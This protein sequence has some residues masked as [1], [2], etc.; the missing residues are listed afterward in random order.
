M[1][2]C[3]R[4]ARTAS[5]QAFVNCYL[6]EVD[7]GS[8][9]SA[10]EFIARTGVHLAPD[11]KSVVEVALLDQGRTIAFGVSHRSLVGRHALIE[12]HESRA[13]AGAYR[14]LD[15]VS[16]QL[17]LIEAIYR[18]APESEQRL[19]LLSRVVE[20]HQLMGKYLRRVTGDGRESI[21]GARGSFIE[22]EQTVVFGHWLHP[23]PK[24]RRGMHEWQHDH[25]A[26]E[27]G[28][29]FRLHF[30][31]A[32]RHLVRQESMREA[33]AEQLA[34][35]VALG[36]VDSSK[37]H[38]KIEPL[39]KTHCL[40]PVHPLQAQWLLHT[41]S[42]RELLDVGELIDLGAFGPEFTATSSVRT[43][44]SD[45]CDL[46]LKLSIP[47]KITNSLRINLA[48]ELGDS[49]WL[50]KYMKECS[51][52]EAFP[53]FR[54]LLDPAAMTLA[55]SNGEE[56]GF[57]VIFRDNPFSHQGGR[58]HA[59]V[60]SIAALVQDPLPG[61]TRS[62]LAEW[63][64]LVAE[65]QEI[66]CQE[67]AG[68][69]F[70]AYWDCAI[71]PAIRIYDEHGLALEAH[72]QNVLLEFSSSGLPC[73]FYYRDI[74]GVA[75][76]ELAR[77]RAVRRVPELDRQDKIFEPDVLVRHG[78]GYYLFFNQ[79]YSVINR[80]SLDGLKAEEALLDFV[81]SKLQRLR[82]SLR[83]FARP[84]V[85]TMLFEAS[86]PCKANLL[87]RMQDLDELRSENEL[88]VY[89][90]VVNPLVARRSVFPSLDGADVPPTS[91]HEH[92]HPVR[93]SSF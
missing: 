45:A 37:V 1:F 82:G 86:I 72:Q 69:W 13:P 71:D 78:F 44:Y 39:V 80:L 76:T 48:N 40:L 61:A 87:T 49:V 8:W 89:H 24:S 23:T 5:L 93:L 56:S 31:A 9:T 55:L 41:E 17:A 70:E 32:P 59:S 4:V 10:G 92:S 54:P 46:M 16:V 20:S 63:I 36:G 66:S 25:Y 26:P 68:R 67:A 18:H 84:F 65:N 28:G 38:A 22:S 33:S 11:T 79:L 58:A 47:V 43:V 7:P 42:V 81:Q 14:A 53:T 35:R 2:D 77:S 91:D 21:P 6:R 75:L 52:E 74:Q 64:G 27:E 19:E 73:A 85:E 90:T 51:L 12:A 83:G 3:A 30:F 50:S 62:V 57:E 15:E 88:A 29:R 60:H 34:Q